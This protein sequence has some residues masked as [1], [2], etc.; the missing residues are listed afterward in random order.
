[1]SI[2]SKSTQQTSGFKKWRRT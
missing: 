1:M 2:W